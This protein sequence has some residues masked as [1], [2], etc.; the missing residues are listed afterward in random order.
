[1]LFASGLI[2]ER[3]PLEVSQLPAA[4]AS[5]LRDAGVLAAIA[6]AVWA[7]AYAM[8]RPAWAR[9]GWSPRA[10]VF[11]GL[12]G[13]SAVLYAVFVALVLI[14]G[15]PPPAPRAA[16][17][18]N[19]PAPVPETIYTP[20]QNLVLV[21][22][23]GLALAAVLLPIVLDFGTRIRWRRIWALARLSLKEAWSKGIVWVALIIPLIYLYSDW[24]LTPA[25][26]K[27]QL[28]QRV[29]VVYYALTL[30]IV[31]TALLLGSF[32]IPT[33]VRNQ[34]IHTIVTKPVERYEIFLGRF[35]GYALLLLA[36]VMVLS[37][38][39]L[40]YAVRGLDREA[41]EESFRAR[42]PLL[43]KQLDFYN[44]R[45]ESVGR[46]WAYRKYFGNLEAQPAGNTQYAQW[47]FTRVPAALAE[48]GRKE[49]RVEYSF[50][51]FR[52]TKGDE[53][54][55]GVECTFIF[56]PGGLS[57]P[58]VE[59]KVRELE[60]EHAQTPETTIAKL[61]ET[62]GI[63]VARKVKVADYHTG[64]LDVPAVLFRKLYA[65]QGKDDPKAREG[66]TPAMQVLVSLDRSS[67]PQMLGV[68]RRDL[69]ILA[70]EQP[71][72]I[73][74]LK[75]SIGL[76]FVACLVLGIAL[77]CS[78]YLSGV[79]SLLTTAFLCGAGLFLDYIKSIAFGTTSGG[80]PF[81]AAFRLANRQGLVVQLD[82]NN[83]TVD[84]FRTLDMGY[85]WYLRRV[86]S[87]IPDVSRFDLTA[88]VANGFD[89][90]W[91]Q[92]LFADTLMPLLGYLIP[93]GV[94]AYYLIN[95][96]EIANPT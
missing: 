67:G 89:V 90:S 43:A 59:A 61:A 95:S 39:S 18:P 14:Q 34:T 37:G 52:T 54:V 19:L 83:P 29:K 96:R 79:I 4:I 13:L 93:C 24:Y 84:V 5:W 87:L 47:F 38:L 70:D 3:D 31:V 88:Y 8:Q 26:P 94:L 36:E 85:R 82:Q 10:A 20:L 73:N 28:A 68:A 58:L 9:R 78:T 86:L 1:M 91:G 32:S 92:V 48:E 21:T 6:L 75:G 74:F 77:T 81:E 22:A 45:G 64:V 71:F 2:I 42:V 44:T 12:A 72:W 11:A 7:V 17:N 50:D 57:V 69:Y 27:D 23:G 66:P 62:Y 40:F 16:A 15:L 49:V 55:Q 33:D 25:L 35:L 80:G 63:W 41:E 56:A 60:K 76:W 46:E 53:R 30:L 51:I 65:D